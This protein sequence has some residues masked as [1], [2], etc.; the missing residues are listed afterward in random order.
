MLKETLDNG[1]C[2]NSHSKTPM[3]VDLDWEQRNRMIAW[4]FHDES[5]EKPCLCRME[6]QPYDF[7][8]KEQ[9]PLRG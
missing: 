4:G 5:L 7:T 2:S 1:A 9:K 6:M 3:P 8:E